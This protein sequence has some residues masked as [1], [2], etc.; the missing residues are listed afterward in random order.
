[1]TGDIVGLVHALH[2]ER[3]IIVGHD[4]GAPVAWHCTLLRPD[5]FYAVVL[6]SVP[7]LQ[8]SWE[9]PRPTEAMRYLAGE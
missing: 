5:T 9:D 7:Y 4:S 8:R 2:Q 1:L 3:A 6:L